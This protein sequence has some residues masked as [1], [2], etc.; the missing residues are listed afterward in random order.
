MKAAMCL[1]LAQTMASTAN[2]LECFSG[3]LSQGCETADIEYFET[4]TCY[5]NLDTCFLTWT[6]SN[7]CT[8]IASG[9]TSTSSSTCANSLGEN[10][11]CCDEDFCNHYGDE[12]SLD[13]LYTCLT[14]TSKDGCPSGNNEN[15]ETRVCPTGQ[16]TCFRH[17]NTDGD[18]CTT[19]RGGCIED[20]VC[21]EFERGGF[22]CCSGD[23]CNTAS[24]QG[25][26]N[27]AGVAGIGAAAIAVAGIARMM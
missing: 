2:A 12:D 1:V 24:L 19:V 17:W 20:S 14:G 25:D 26:G 9:C 21:D 11:L 7:G 3:A 16:N 13:H 5:G 18:G 22:A 23:D 27:S 6:Y 10:V 8:Q 4:Q 15:M